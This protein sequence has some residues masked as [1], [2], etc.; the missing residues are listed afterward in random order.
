MD[1]TAR[2]EQALA[3]ALESA[4]TQS[5][6]PR[7]AEAVR[8]AVFPGGARVRP[9]L[10]LAVAAACGSRDVEAADAVAASIE[11]LHCASLVHDDLPCF[12][13]S[14]LRRGLPSVHRAFGEP[15][16]VLAGD[17]LIVL[18]FENLARTLAGSPERLAPLLMTVS[19]AVGMPSGIVAGQAWECE[20][21]VSVAD[22]HRA[23]TG[24]L[25]AAATAAGAQVA[26][27]DADAWRVVGDRIGEAYQVADDLRDVAASAQEVGKPVGRD[28]LLHRP[29]AA[30]ELGVTGAVDLL[31]GLVKDAIDAIPPCPGAQ[32][33]AEVL[34]SESRH[35]MP[36]DLAD[37]AA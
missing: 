6:P 20:P 26:G 8:H 4:M 29:S 7:L 31:R 5:C 2:I 12:D 10:C 23:K 3:S 15:L 22:Y 13:D 11:L 27:A 37:R 33:L 30:G 16:A 14:P 34:L 25:F 28:A 9:R 18:A 21:R 32:Q 36:K 35:I 24:A 1:A 17:A 19:R